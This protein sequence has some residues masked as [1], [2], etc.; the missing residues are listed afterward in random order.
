MEETIKHKNF[1]R[2]AE[3]R[4]EKALDMIDLI[5][6]LSNKSFYEYTQEEV[7]TIFDALQKALDENKAKY[8]IN[9][10]IKRRFTL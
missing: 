10:K 6:N 3:S 9:S 4:T 5:G 1:K 2:L 8:K 7:E